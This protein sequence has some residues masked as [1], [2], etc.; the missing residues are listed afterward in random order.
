M[1]P[2][3]IIVMMSPGTAVEPGRVTD[4]EPEWVMALG[5][6]GNTH[7]FTHSPRAGSIGSAFSFF[8]RLL[9]LLRPIT[10]VRILAPA[11]EIHMQKPAPSPHLAKT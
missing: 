6:G 10:F 7:S 3:V 4:E 9:F 1:L 5:T 2:A 8:K 11:E